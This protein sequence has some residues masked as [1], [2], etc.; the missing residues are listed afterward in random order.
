MH[1]CEQ[2][3]H[4]LKYELHIRDVEIKPVQKFNYLGSIVTDSKSEI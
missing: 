3:G 2:K 4:S 1:G